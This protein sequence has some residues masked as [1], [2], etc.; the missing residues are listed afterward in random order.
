[1]SEENVKVL[2]RVVDAFNRGDLQS[3]K[4]LFTQDAEIVPLRAEVENTIFRGPGA[5]EE[6]FAATQESWDAAEL[7]VEEIKDGGDWLL[8]FG[9]FQARGRVSGAEIS[10][11]PAWIVRF[12]DGAITSLHSFADPKDALVAA[13]LSE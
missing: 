2:A 9:S 1:M 10:V 12:R 8:V 3:F 4:T 13:G 11:N 5:P 6:F 7:G